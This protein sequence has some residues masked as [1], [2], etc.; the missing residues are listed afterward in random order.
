MD[1]TSRKT[2]VTFYRRPSGTVCFRR[3]SRREDNGETDKSSCV[4]TYRWNEKKVQVRLLVT[5]TLVFYV[6]SPPP[7][8]PPAFRTL[9]A[10][11]TQLNNQFGIF[12]TFLYIPFPPKT[13]FFRYKC[14]LW[15]IL[16]NIWQIQ[17]WTKMLRKMHV[18]CL[19][20]QYF[21]LKPG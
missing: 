1:V 11:Q 9:T 2:R 5:V 15:P 8:P 7:P 10:D 16:F 18:V 17:S 13:P 14:S 6:H 20:S 3:V 19:I 21:P 4:L 12:K